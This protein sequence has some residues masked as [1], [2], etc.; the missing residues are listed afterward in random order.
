MKPIDAAK[1]SAK[2]GAPI[3]GVPLFFWMEEFGGMSNQQAL[4]LLA[5]LPPPLLGKIGWF[6][7]SITYVETLGWVIELRCAMKA[8]KTPPKNTMHFGGVGGV[9]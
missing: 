5:Y 1:N 7:R 3:G 2:E 9:S 4:C 6:W 8:N